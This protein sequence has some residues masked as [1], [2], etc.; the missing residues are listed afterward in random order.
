MADVLK[1]CAAAV[2]A[3]AFQWQQQVAAIAEVLG[4]P[5]VLAANAS[6]PPYAN[7]SAGGLALAGLDLPIAP[8]LAAS[9]PLLSDLTV[10]GNRFINTGSHAID[11]RLV[12]SGK[13]SGNTFVNSGQ[14]RA[15]TGEATAQ[16]DTQPVLLKQSADIIVKDNQ[17]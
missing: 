2:P 4:T 16:D 12:S 5:A 9:T 1:L 15:L 13:I 3:V 14:P 6:L 17:Q 7:V 11:F 8:W 10:C